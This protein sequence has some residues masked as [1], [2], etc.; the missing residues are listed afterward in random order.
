MLFLMSK[1]PDKSLLS[2]YQSLQDSNQNKYRNSKTVMIQ[3]L[4]SYD[5]T[6][7]QDCFISPMFFSREADV[8]AFGGIESR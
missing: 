5:G 6:V 1:L 7:L 4:F 2:H 3:Y 8:F